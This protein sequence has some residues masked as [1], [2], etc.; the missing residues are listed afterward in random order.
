MQSSWFLELTCLHV[1]AV[2][3]AAAGANA[4]RGLLLSIHCKMV[5]K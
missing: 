3:A 5:F 4:S 2:A 1:E